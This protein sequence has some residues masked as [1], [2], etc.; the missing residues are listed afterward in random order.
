MLLNWLLFYLH[1]EQFELKSKSLK[2]SC[3]FKQQLQ[4]FIKLKFV[5]KKSS[6]A[7]TL[8]KQRN[9]IGWRYIFALQTYGKGFISKLY[10]VHIILETRN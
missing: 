8:K 7:N 6:A 9:H 1:Y 3:N 10:T 4:Q 2:Y 5:A